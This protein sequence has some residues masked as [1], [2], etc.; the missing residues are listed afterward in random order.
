MGL[1]DPTRDEKKTQKK[2]KKTTQFDE[3][4]TASKKVMTAEDGESRLESEMEEPSC[5]IQ[6]TVPV[7]T[8]VTQE[9]VIDEI[10]NSQKSESSERS[11]EKK[12]KSKRHKKKKRE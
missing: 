4:M 8:A 3:F 9:Q 1:S 2:A 10:C 12:S 11:V 7:P 6:T 5:I